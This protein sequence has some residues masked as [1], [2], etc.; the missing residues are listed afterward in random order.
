MTTHRQSEQLEAGSEARPEEARLSRRGMV[1]ALAA[2]AAVSAVTLLRS[3][4]SPRAADAAPGN[5]VV[6][7]VE[8]S[9]EANTATTTASRKCLI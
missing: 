3:R 9:A 5:E 2:G 8:L 6:C 1:A 4:I 7:A